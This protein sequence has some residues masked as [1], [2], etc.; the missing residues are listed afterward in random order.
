MIIKRRN[1]I[2]RRIEKNLRF[3]H[4]DYTCICEDL[5][6]STREDEKRY[7]SQLRDARLEE[8]ERIRRYEHELRLLSARSNNRGGGK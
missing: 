8:L 7:R 1:K 4:N 3:H 6:E 5:R 2:I